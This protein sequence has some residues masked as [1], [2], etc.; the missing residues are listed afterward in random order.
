MKSEE[1]IVSFNKKK[2]TADINKRLLNDCHKDT[3]RS[4]NEK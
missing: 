3:L 4:D 2:R 1:E